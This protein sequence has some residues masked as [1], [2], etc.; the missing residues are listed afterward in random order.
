MSAI[1]DL[2]GRFETLLA[3]LKAA[4]PEAVQR[5]RTL[6]HRAL[7]RGND[8][9]PE[10][11][12]WHGMIGTCPPMMQVRRLIEKFAPANA[13]VLVRGESGTGKDLIARALHE[14]SPRRGETLLAENCAAIPETLLESVLFGHVKGSFTG[15][16]RDHEGHFV[17]A[18]GGTLFL[19]EVGD[20]PLSM[21]AKLLRVL[22]EG[23]VRAVGSTK[24]R[25][26]DVRVVAATNKDLEAMVRE[27]SFREDLFYRLNVLRLELPP[28]R[29]RGADREILA[30]HFL[31]AA[32]EP[33]GRELTLGEA[34]MEVIRGCRWPGNIRQLQNEM[35]RIAT[36]ADGPEVLVEDFSP[37]VRRQ[38]E[39]P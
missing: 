9:G 16:V 15:A 25:K 1:D 3:E 7:Y 14:L 35:Q 10:P 34:A 29:D 33:M 39:A 2:L 18:D 37:E 24:V 36:L 17:A 22:Q 21:Q 6:V 4:G 28:L 12:K 26:V 30:R 32:V 13:P 38:L 5:A 23:E 31:A 27:R 20:M 8:E 19:D 11:E